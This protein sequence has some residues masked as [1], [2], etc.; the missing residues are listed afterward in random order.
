MIQTFSRPLTDGEESSTSKRIRKPWTL[1][2]IDGT[3]SFIVGMPTYSNLIRFGVEEKRDEI[4]FAFFP[5][6]ENII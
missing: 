4:G 3:K 1:D 5:E 6:L 2:P